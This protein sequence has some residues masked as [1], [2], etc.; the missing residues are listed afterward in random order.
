[1]RRRW[2]VVGRGWVEGER[3]R[4]DER[5]ERER[6]GRVRVRREYDGEEGGVGE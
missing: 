1:L 3:L 5:G 2:G 6:R 4:D